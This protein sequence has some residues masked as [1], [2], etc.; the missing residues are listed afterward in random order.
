[1]KASFAREVGNFAA[2]YREGEIVAVTEKGQV[3]GLNRGRQ[4]KK[5]KRSRLSWRRSTAGDCRASRRPKIF[6][7]SA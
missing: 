1:M 2:E 4:E 3:Y 6:S 7:N 5:R